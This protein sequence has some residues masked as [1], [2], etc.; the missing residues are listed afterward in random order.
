MSAGEGLGALGARE[1]SKLVARLVE[2]LLVVGGWV[3]VG[4]AGLVCVWVSDLDLGEGNAWV[5]QE[6]VCQDTQ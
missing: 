2:K 1:R 4:A 6:A 3:W 5:W